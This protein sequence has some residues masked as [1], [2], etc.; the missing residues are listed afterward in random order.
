MRSTISQGEHYD[1]ELRVAVLLV[2]VLCAVCLVFVPVASATITVDQF[3]ANTTGTTVGDGQCVALVDQGLLQVYGIT[4]GAWGNAVDYQ[5]GGTAGN[6][7]A[8][9]GFTWSTDQNFANGDI[10]CG[11]LEPTRQTWARRRLVQRGEFRATTPGRLDYT[12]SSSGFLGHWRK[13]L[14]NP[15]STPVVQVGDA[16][17]D[18]VQASWSSVDPESGIAE[19]QY[20]LGTAP[21]A[22]NLMAWTSV[23]TSTGQAIWGLDADSESE[24]VGE[25]HS[26]GDME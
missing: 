12:R 11:E 19:Y 3:V 17:P 13:G 21:G 16:G 15:P 9:D 14:A 5:A 10:L 1:R 18:A 6:H 8:A 25:G 22:S 4:T 24:F 7:L 23:G 2:V 20:C 26:R